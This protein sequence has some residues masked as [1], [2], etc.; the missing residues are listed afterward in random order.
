MKKITILFASTSLMAAGCSSHSDVNE[1]KIILQD[2]TLRNEIYHVILSDS[3]Y[4]RELGKQIAAHKDHL[5]HH[6]SKAIMK[7]LCMPGGMDSTMKCKMNEKSRKDSSACK[8]MNAGVQSEE[9]SAVQKVK[10][11]KH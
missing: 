6:D 4:F 1:A 7:A 9:K 11:H 2:S 10:P 3:T 8:M 5:N